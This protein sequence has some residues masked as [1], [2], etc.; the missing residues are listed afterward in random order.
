MKIALR[1][2][3]IVAISLVAVPAVAAEDDAGYY[4]GLR[5]IG[6]I[7]NL[8][9]VRATGFT[10]SLDIRHD[11]DQTAGFG[12][13]LGY[14]WSSL[15]VRTEV[16]VAYR[17]RFDFDNRDV[18]PP[19]IGF[20]NNLATLTTL[21]NLLFEYRNKTNFTPYFGGTA[22]WSQN[23]SSTVRD[24]IGAGTR[25]E[26]ENE[27]NNFAWGAMLGISWRFTGNWEA[28]LGYR[29][30]NLGEVDTGLFSTGDKVT[31]DDYVAHDV[32]VSVHYR[33]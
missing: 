22:G 9:D 20:E 28:D 7:A 2:A 8:D 13:Y 32:M 26:Q 12:G 25:V 30:I 3:A 5:I 1:T 31:A 17:V 21:F 33:F 4:A 23:R 18:G 24:D 14:R 11:N 19:V 16:E 10:G 27:T 15:P 29:F 6:S